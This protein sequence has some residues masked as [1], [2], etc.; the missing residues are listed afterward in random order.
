MVHVIQNVPPLQWDFDLWPIVRNSDGLIKNK[1]LPL[2]TQGSLCVGHVAQG[3]VRWSQEAVLLL[4]GRLGGAALQVDERFSLQQHAA[5]AQ[6]PPLLLVPAVEDVDPVVQL[7]AGR[8]R[9][10]GAGQLQVDRVHRQPLLSQARVLGQRREQLLHH[11][12]GVLGGEGRV[13]AAVGGLDAAATAAA[14]W[15]VA[16]GAAHPLHGQHGVGHGGGGASRQVNVDG[17]RR[18]DLSSECRSSCIFKGWR[19][20]EDWMKKRKIY[21]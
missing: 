21:G 2:V 5:A 10:S 20:R 8:L 3:R 15:G 14:G 1:S 16:H 6:R 17:C 9:A 19:F 12:A 7:R 13:A 18:D 4:Q 11:H